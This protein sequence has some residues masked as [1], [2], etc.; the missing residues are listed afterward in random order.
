MGIKFIIARG[1]AAKLFEATEQPLNGVALGVA[2]PVVGSGKAALA[3][4]RNHDL[5]AAGGQLG[6]QLVTVVGAVGNKHL[7]GQ[8]VEQR[9][10]LRGIVGL[11]GGEAQAYGPALSITDGVQLS[12]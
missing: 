7:R 8:P 6:Y 4:G 9:Q 1:Q 11:T 2:C 3:A 10:G 5:R 12:G